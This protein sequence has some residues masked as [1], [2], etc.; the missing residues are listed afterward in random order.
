MRALGLVDKGDMFT[1]MARQPRRLEAAIKRENFIAAL[2][3]CA[4]KKL[5]QGRNPD[6]HSLPA[7]RSHRSLQE[8]D[9]AAARSRADSKRKA[10]TQTGL[11]QIKQFTLYLES[12]A[13]AAE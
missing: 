1:E 4:T 9:V 6:V 12:A 11:F 7:V 13:I 2:K 8:G 5:M 3:R 10:R